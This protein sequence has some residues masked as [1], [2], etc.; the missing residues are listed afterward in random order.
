MISTIAVSG[1][2][3]RLAEDPPKWQL[4]DFLPMGL[5][6]IDILVFIPVFIFVSLSFGRQ[7]YT[8]C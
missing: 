6:F 1:L 3:K 2:A 8:P 7:P 4:P 5:V